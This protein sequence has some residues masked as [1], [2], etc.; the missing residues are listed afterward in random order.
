MSF[1][2]PVPRT[3]IERKPKHG[4]QCNRCGACCY[5]SLCDL[6]AEVHRRRTGPC[7]SLVMVNGLSSC[8]LIEGST[9]AL[10][11]AAK[12]LI[13]S[14]MGCD[15]KLT[16]E[17]RDFEYTARC[18]ALDRANRDRLAAARRLWGME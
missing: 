16:S 7:P 17:P 8:G 5:A 13:N 9:G 3:M 18:D 2:A 12:L 10:R 6:G 4:A 11:D 14:S 15:M 1:I